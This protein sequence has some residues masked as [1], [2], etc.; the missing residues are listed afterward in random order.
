M[1]LDL[2][3][4]TL[5][6]SVALRLSREGLGPRAQHGVGVDL[7]RH[8]LGIEPEMSTSL[9]DP[10]VLSSRSQTLRSFTKG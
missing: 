5:R 1:Q 3:H 9:D 7:S 6:I 8:T 10:G 4:Q 2:L